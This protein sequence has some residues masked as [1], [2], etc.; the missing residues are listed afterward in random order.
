MQGIEHNTCKD[1]WNKE[2]YFAVMKKISE[3]IL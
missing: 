3:N 1:F 2:A